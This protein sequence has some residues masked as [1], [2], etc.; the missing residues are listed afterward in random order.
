M[1]K[2]MNELV[3]APADETGSEAATVTETAA[4]KKRKVSE[5]TVLD[6][7]GKAQDEWLDA[8]G[9]G[10]K[11]LAED[12]DLKVMFT[13]LPDPVMRGLAAF[14]GVTLAG[15][16][17]N[18][19]RNDPNKADDASEKEALI[20]WIENL[21][22]GNWTSPRGEVEAGLG[23]LAEAYSKAMAKVGKDISTEAALEKLKA[24]DKDKRKAVRTDSRVKAE[25]TAILAER[26]KAKAAETEGE[27]V[28]L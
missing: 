9:F 27:L 10:Y 23:L 20:A 8:W 14:G 2:L 19:V 26:A 18:T 4:P 12:F 5:R 3:R 11:S 16:T 7:D 22:A 21:K 24:A 17:T 13:D 25:L 28:E 1:I 15:N 6:Q